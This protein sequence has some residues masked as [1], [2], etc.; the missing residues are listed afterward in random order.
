MVDRYKVFQHGGGVIS[1]YDYPAGWYVERLVLLRIPQQQRYIIGK[2]YGQGGKPWDSKA[3][4]EAAA[5]RETQHAVWRHIWKQAFNSM[6]YRICE[7]KEETWEPVEVGTTSLPAYIEDSV[8]GKMKMMNNQVHHLIVTITKH[9]YGQQA[10][11]ARLLGYVSA[12]ANNPKFRGKPHHHRAY[13]AMNGGQKPRDPAK[14]DLLK[15]LAEP[16][17]NELAWKLASEKLG[18]KIKH[19]HKV[20]K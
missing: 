19:Y 17:G 20:Q 7:V 14:A 10:M 13:T 1:N 4:A 8:K 9:K 12:N 16:D 3:K 2:A 11:L 6:P 5:R 18:A 15:R